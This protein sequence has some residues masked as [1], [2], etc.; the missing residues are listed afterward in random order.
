[1]R[2]RRQN[3]EDRCP[4]AIARERANM[5]ALQGSLPGGSSECEGTETTRLTW[6]RSLKPGGLVRVSGAVSGRNRE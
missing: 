3:V 1:V 6:R 5:Y 2:R 4:R